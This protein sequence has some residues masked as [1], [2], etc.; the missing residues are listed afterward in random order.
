MN[1]CTNHPKL[2]TFNSI[3]YT[4]RQQS[5]M[6]PFL[7]FYLINRFR[8]FL[9]LFFH[10]FHYNNVKASQNRHCDLTVISIQMKTYVNNTQ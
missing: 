1:T 7:L 5:D 4:K 6:L 3:I 9:R 10:I 8:K 2:R